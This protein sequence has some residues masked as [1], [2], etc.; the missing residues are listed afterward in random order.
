MELNCPHCQRRNRLPP[1]RL[2]ELPNCGA[3]RAP[4]LEGGVLELDAGSFDAL[5]AHAPRPVLVDFWAPWCSPCLQFAPT[6]LATAKILSE[7]YV[8]AKLDTEAEPDI[9][10]RTGI[11]SIPTLVLFHEG[12]EL[13]RRSGALP[14]PELRRWLLMQD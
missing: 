5:I 13:S 10:A 8:F 7:R 12:R 14:G 9:A 2:P 1:E 11:R 6:Y 3:C 4:L